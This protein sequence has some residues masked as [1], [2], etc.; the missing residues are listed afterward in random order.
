VPQL[1]DLSIKNVPLPTQGR[2]TIWDDN[3]PLGVRITAKG[4]KTFVVM[5]GPGRR[6]TLGRYGDITLSQARTAAKQLKA[7]QTLGRLIPS[8]RSVSDARTEYLKTLAVRPNT[9]GYYERNLHRLPDCRLT[10][11]T[12]AD[13]HKILDALRPTSRGQALKTYTAFFNWCIRR[14]YLDTSPCIR[15][16]AEKSTSRSRVLSDEEL[17]KIWRACEHVTALPSVDAA[18]GTTHVAPCHLPASYC[19][20]VKLLILTGQRK[21]EIANLQSSWIK[22]DKITFPKEITK[23]ARVHTIP[24]PQLA[25]DVIAVPLKSSTT[26][27]LFP[28]QD[29]S[30]PFNNWSNC[31]VI[32]DN[33]CGV[34][35]W[36][37][38]DLRRTFASNLAAL[39]VRIEVIEKIL[40]HTS[41]QLRGVAGIYNRHAYWE[42][43]RSALDLWEAKL[44]TLIK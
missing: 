35:D 7:E 8:S 31:K 2:V 44:M 21:S 22:N 19:T 16:R 42:E 4:A 3:S 20:I 9:R 23:N 43:M 41:G 28:G 15:F 14:Y 36:T 33:V 37:I 13:L 27:F 12:A 32:L 40:N 17:G 30:K 24:I 6:H 11:L 38:H 18:L 29:T 26:A 10:E 5:L 1:S 34:K 39:G 25:L